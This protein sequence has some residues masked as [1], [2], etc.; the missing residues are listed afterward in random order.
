MGEIA[1]AVAESIRNR[2]TSI[3]LVTYT[4]FWSA[5]HW[6]GLYTTLFTSQDMIYKKFGLLKNEYAEKYFFGWHSWSS[7]WGL[8]VPATETF[9]FIWALQKWV[10]VPMYG[11]EQ[12]NRTRRRLI[13]LAE[14]KK[15]QDAKARLAKEETKKTVAETRK[16]VA[17]TTLQRRKKEAEKVDPKIVWDDEFVKFKGSRDYG[18]FSQILRC[19]YQYSGNTK[20][21]ADYDE[22]EFELSPRS[23]MMADTRGLITI[24][25]SGN[26]I[27]LTD[28]GKYFAS[29]Y[30]RTF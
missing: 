17:K 13:K 7:V 19:V 16:V 6:Q 21:A 23:M 18:L 14:N 20:V 28:K 3:T 30:D 1:S 29:L 2:A 27:A 26:K 12:D 4:F 5:W 25:S 24:A 10:L 9:I 8:V 15:I 22:F 11:I